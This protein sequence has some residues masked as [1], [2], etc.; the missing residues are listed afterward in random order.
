[1]SQFWN[2]VGRGNLNSFDTNKQF[3]Y[4]AKVE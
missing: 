3:F 2:T 1:M 4:A